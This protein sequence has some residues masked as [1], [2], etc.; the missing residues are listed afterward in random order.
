VTL[1]S[2]TINECAQTLEQRLVTF[3]AYGI[4]DLQTAL[5]GRCTLDLRKRGKVYFWKGNTKRS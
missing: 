4:S 1:S 3:S 5:H 2:L